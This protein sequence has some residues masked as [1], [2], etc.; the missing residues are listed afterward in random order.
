M[1]VCGE[2]SAVKWTR[3]QIVA[4]SLRCRS[5]LCEDCFP[6]RRR[7][8]IAQAIGGKPTRF[9]TITSRKTHTYTPE[10][11]ARRM[12]RAWAA[13]RKRIVRKYGLRCLPFFLVVEQHKSG[14]P[15]FHILARCPYIDHKWLSKQLG[16]LCDGPVV[17]IEHL[18]SAHRIAVYCAKYCG[19]CVDKIGNTKRYWQSRDWDLRTEA[20]GHP[21]DLPTVPWKIVSDPLPRLVWAWKEFG[22]AVTQPTR[23]KAVCTREL[24]GRGP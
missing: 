11:A 9:I 1:T 22:W 4:V 24:T 21:V 5:W 3:T 20:Y 19:K 23:F 16:E 13:V 6:Q 2:I 15:H 10:D 12:S 18:N 7:Q 8:L 17:W 14:W